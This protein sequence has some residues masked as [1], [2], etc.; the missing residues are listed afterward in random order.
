MKMDQ[1][2]KILF[3]VIVILIALAS[4][5]QIKQDKKEL[6]DYEFDRATGGQYMQTYN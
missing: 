6:S 3:A 5:W 2:Q 4:F 1:E